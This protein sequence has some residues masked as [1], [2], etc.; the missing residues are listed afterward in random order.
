MIPTVGKMILTVGKMVPTVGKMVL[1]V[2]KMVP[3]V[4]KMVR[5]VGKMI[6]T[7]GKMVKIDKKKHMIHKK[8]I[9]LILT[10]AF[11][12]GIYA[13]IQNNPPMR[14]VL[15]STGRSHT[16][17]TMTLD[18]TV[19]EPMVETYTPG[20]PF[21][22]KTL[23][24]GFQQPMNN[25]FSINLI[26]VNSTCIGAHNGSASL[27]VLSST[28]PVSYTWAPPLVSTA[29]FVSNLAPG[30]YHYTATDGTFTINDSVII[31]EDQVNCISPLEF[32]NGIT[33]NGD[34][35]NDWW[36]I[37]HIEDYPEN[38]VS[39]FNRWGNL[40]WKK[41]GYNN[42]DIRWDG[43]NSNGVALP[44]ATYFYVVEITGKELK[45]WVELTH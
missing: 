44:D 36:Y 24:Q 34:G 39:I 12:S 1:T 21:T 27:G 3:T 43:S 31:T 40:V 29:N 23:T 2:G 22:I 6:L 33:P 20:S 26:Y 16:S 41:S 17:A 14:Q 42:L 19:G 9:V 18:Y 45:G 28:G 15:G 38:T 7:V 37:T 30:T 32:Y 10:I 4:G 25:A 35:N 11:A 13:Q 8:Y 5:T